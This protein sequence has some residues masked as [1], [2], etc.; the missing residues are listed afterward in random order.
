MLLFS[1]LSH[2]LYSLSVGTRD[3]KTNDNCIKL[4]AISTGWARKL[5]IKL[6]AMMQELRW[7]SR[8]LPSSFSRVVAR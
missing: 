5:R 8:A 7:L 6:M 3:N 4:I 2:L 1:R